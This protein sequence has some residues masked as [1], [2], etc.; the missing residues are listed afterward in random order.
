MFILNHD[1]PDNTSSHLIAAVTAFAVYGTF[2]RPAPVPEYWAHPALD[3][4]ATAM[5]LAPNASILSG[6]PRFQVS[7]ATSAPEENVILSGLLTPLARHVGA[8]MVLGC[9]SLALGPA[10]TTIDRIDVQ[11]IA[12]E[13]S[14]DSL[15]ELLSRKSVDA[16]A[17]EPCDAVLRVSHPDTASELTGS[18]VRQTS[19]CDIAPFEVTGSVPGPRAAS[20]P[21]AMVDDLDPDGDATDHYQVTLPNWSLMS[22]GWIFDLLLW[23]HSSIGL[24]RRQHLVMSLSPR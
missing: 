17:V 2:Q 9:A 20:R 13:P 18:V 24:N 14:A 23:A 7:E 3:S 16:L 11:A 6:S 5:G 10:V 4:A 15:P 19:R 8:Q 12:G 22:A 1:A 21:S